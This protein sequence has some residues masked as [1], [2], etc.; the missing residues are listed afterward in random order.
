M[1]DGIPRTEL[2]TAQNRTALW[3]N[4]RKL[5]SKPAAG[6]GSKATYRGDK[7]TKRVW[8]KLSVGTYVAQAS[9]SPSERHL[10]DVRTEPPLK[11]DIRVSA[12]AGA[13]NQVAARLYRGQTTN[14]RTPGSGFVPVLTDSWSCCVLA[15]AS[16]PHN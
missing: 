7:L 3:E 15:M 8:Q 2:L 1:Q 13:I 11:I 5:F 9:V 16:V 14:F 12:Y 6:H 10:A 4:R